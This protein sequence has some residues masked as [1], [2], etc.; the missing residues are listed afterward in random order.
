VIAEVNATPLQEKR[1]VLTRV[2]PVDDDAELGGSVACISAPMR[3]TDA[4]EETTRRDV[5]SSAGAYIREI[6]LGIFWTLSRGAS[7]EDLT[8]LTRIF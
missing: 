5:G 3:W 4:S 2:S 1:N 7:Y 8:G 6:G